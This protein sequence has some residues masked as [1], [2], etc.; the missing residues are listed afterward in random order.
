MPGSGTALPASGYVAPLSWRQRRVYRH[1]C[2][3]YE[4]LP[5]DGRYGD[6]WVV[7]ATGVP[8]HFVKR[9]GAPEA[10]LLASIESSGKDSLDECH[11]AE[12]QPLGDDWLIVDKTLNR[13]GDPGADY[14]DA[15][16]VLGSPKSV[17]AVGTR[18]AGKKIAFLGRSAVKPEGAE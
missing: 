4:K 6:A 5:P 2:D 12:R 17:A 18:D 13:D 9:S 16:K 3:I 15:W 8:C 11:L 1:T 14:G 10:E 7:N